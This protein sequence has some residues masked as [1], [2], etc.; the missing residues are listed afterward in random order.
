MKKLITFL[1]AVVLSAV[2]VGCSNN[3]QDDIPGEAKYVDFT[4]YCITFTY[5]EDWQLFSCDEVR[6]IVGKAVFVVSKENDIA[7]KIFCS[8]TGPVMQTI[9]ADNAMSASIVSEMRK[10]L[11]TTVNPSSTY[12][13]IINGVITAE[14]LIKEGK[15]CPEYTGDLLKAERIDSIEKVERVVAADDGTLAAVKDKTGLWGY[16][17][18][19]GAFVIAPQFVEARDFKE[20]MAAVATES[21]GIKTWGY[22]RRDG[23]Y[24]TGLTNYAYAGD[25]NNGLALVSSADN[26]LHYINTNGTIAL[27]PL[28]IEVSG[29]VNFMQ[30]GFA[31]ASDFKNHCAVVAIYSANN[32][33][34]AY[35]IGSDGRMYCY[36]GSN[37]ADE[38]FNSSF[39]LSASGFVMYRA[40]NGKYGMVDSLGI[41]MLPEAYDD[42]RAYGGTLVGVMLDGKYGYVDLANT[43]VVPFRY[44]G[45]TVMNEKGYALVKAEDKWGVID[46]NGGYVLTPRY[47]DAAP[48]C[49]GVCFVKLEGKWGAINESYELVIPAVF[50]TVG[51][52]KNKTAVFSSDQG[53]GFINEE[54]KVIIEPTFIDARSFS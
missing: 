20:N 31:A 3:Q 37:L 48:Y 42:M 32:T 25:F 17:N 4:G 7:I 50:K 13:N 9:V 33:R 45:A 53:F 21:G 39:S 14:S 10:T 26:G 38:T 23:T 16:I 40:E 51:Q 49:E 11:E 43:A 1:M 47:E 44:D 27:S 29:S 12:A 36:I 8:E 22:I 19:K 6:S 41:K 28:G 30:V 5:R 52:M 18:K 54:G 46:K 24:I 2:L 34:D 15:V 35:L